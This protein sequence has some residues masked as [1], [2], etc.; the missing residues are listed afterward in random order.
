MNKFAFG[1]ILVLAFASYALAGEDC[2]KKIDALKTKC[3]ADLKLSNDDVQAMFKGDPSTFTNGTQCLISCIAEN[4]GVYKDGKVIES[5]VLN[6]MSE[7]WKE[8]PEDK[9]RDLAIMK[10][11]KDISEKCPCMTATKI[12]I[13]VKN[14]SAKFTSGKLQKS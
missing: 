14:V 11:C 4:M 12:L 13:C 10:E 8:K 7:H 5:A 9:E 3:Q 2:M 6:I 1:T